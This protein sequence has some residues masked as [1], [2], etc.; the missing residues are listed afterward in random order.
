[1][2]TNVSHQAGSPASSAVVGGGAVAAINWL[3]CT[4]DRWSVATT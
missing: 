2:M 4:H 1:M 3:I